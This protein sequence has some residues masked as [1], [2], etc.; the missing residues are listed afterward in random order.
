MN[1]TCEPLHLIHLPIIPK[2][3][4]Q[5][6]KT[7]KFPQSHT[8]E[9]IAIYITSSL[10]LTSLTDSFV[11]CFCLH[12]V[13][14]PRYS[15]SKRHQCF[16]AV[17]RNTPGVNISIVQFPEQV[18]PNFEAL[19]SDE[20]YSSRDASLR[21]CD[22]NTTTPTSRSIPHSLLIRG[23]MERYRSRHSE[24]RVARY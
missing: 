21:T 3:R 6:L 7:S 24:P 9:Q 8:V 1:V 5:N 12:L 2:L 10:Q 17:G 4:N 15:R 19:A 18:H 23:S 11:L 22:A 13:L 20:D 14:V 16:G